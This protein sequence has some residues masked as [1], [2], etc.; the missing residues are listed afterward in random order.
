MNPVDHVSFRLYTDPI[1]SRTA[2]SNISLYSPTVVVTT[3][4]SV[5]PRPSPATLPRVKRLV[6]LPPAELVCSAVPRRPRIK[7]AFSWSYS[8]DGLKM[9]F[10]YET[11]VLRRLRMSVSCALSELS[12]W[13]PSFFLSNKSKGDGKGSGVGLY[14][15]ETKSKSPPGCGMIHL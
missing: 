14:R 12:L 9:E 10:C 6:S 15:A 5:R 2:I 11:N 8:C 4:T 3:S 13:S 1:T 7:G